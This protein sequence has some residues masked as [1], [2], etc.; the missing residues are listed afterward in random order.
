METRNTRLQNAGH[1]GSLHAAAH[2]PVQAKSAA[3]L[4]DNR[5]GT[6]A[7]LATSVR[8]TTQNF[9]YNDAVTNAPATHPVGKRMVADLDHTDVRT[10][11][12]TTSTE[13]PALF[14]G[15]NAHWDPGTLH[16]VR[17][18]L[19]N[20]HIGGPNTDPNLFPITGHANKTHL[21][22]VESHVKTWVRNNRDVR[23]EVDAVQ[24]GGNVN[25]ERNAAG[26]LVCYA[27]TTDGGPREVV[28]K[29]VLSTP[30]TI[31]GG[32]GGPKSG[33]DVHDHNWW[34]YNNT[35]AGKGN[36]SNAGLHE[37]AGMNNANRATWNTNHLRTGWFWDDYAL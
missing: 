5:P 24:D 11:N 21:N 26:R 6:V 31:I 15:L 4:V 34:Q 27:Y 2:R 23:Y 18:H 35:K 22:E 3:A 9:Q 1:T 17:G 20:A 29:T 19:L 33:V 10:G 16:W 37:N 13:M 28:N 12:K 14:A 36:T 32:G 7:Q 30:H 8:W 25:G